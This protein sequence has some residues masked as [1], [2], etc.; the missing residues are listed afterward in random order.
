MNPNAQSSTATASKTGAEAAATTQPNALGKN[1]RNRRFQL[2]AE[3]CAKL[4]RPFTMLDVG[5]TVEFWQDNVA[6]LGCDLTVIN[7]FEQPAKAGIK[8]LLGDACDLSRFADKSFDVV[9]SNSVIGHVG[10]W[11]Q[12]QK[13]AREVRRVGRRCFLQTPNQ[14]FP[15]DWRTLM[16]FFHWLS[17]AAQAWWFQKI[18]VGRY[19]RAKTRD[20]AWHLATR[21]RNLN[22]REMLTMFPDATLV[23][24]RV[25]GFT[26]SFI[27]HHGF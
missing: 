23:P 4:P 1:F 7:I 21:V 27:V 12:Q 24:E 9:F 2:F 15:V 22:R 20:E 25:A 26:K 19:Q 18:R 5:G 10:G 11:E 3:L 13:M 8:V 16:P 17:P 14:G 6:A